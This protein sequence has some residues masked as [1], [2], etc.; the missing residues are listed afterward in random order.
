MPILLIVD[1]GKF[2]VLEEHLGELKE[3]SEAVH[4]VLQ[5]GDNTMLQESYRDL[6]S[7]LSEKSLRISIVDPRPVD[8]VLPSPHA[9]HDLLRR[10]FIV[11]P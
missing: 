5:A 6:F 4:T 9:G 2:E 11:E 1:V 8:L 7:W 10:I 3:R